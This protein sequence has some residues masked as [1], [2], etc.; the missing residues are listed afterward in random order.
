MQY[1]N[2]YF[3]EI[4]WRLSYIILAFILSISISY[5]HK[6]ELFYLVS[7]PFLFL[8]N[9]FIFFE[10]TEGL[11]SMIR[12]SS[13][14]SL[15]SMIPYII[16][17]FWSFYIPSCYEFERKRINF[18]LYVF[19]FFFLFEFFIIYWFLFP[20]LCEFLLSFEMKSVHQSF[21]SLSLEFA[22]R[23]TPYLTLIVKV[24]AFLLL[25]FQFPL[26]FIGL[27]RKH[28]VSSYNLC[29][30][31]K[32]S[33]FCCVLVSALISPPDFMSQLILSCIF[34]LIFELIIF[35]GFLFEIEDFEK[36]YNMIK[37]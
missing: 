34:Y 11:Y 35:I 9:Q 21:S 19:S 7:K 28:I 17:Q 12:I 8:S 6:Y 13:I 25:V 5:F 16:Y 2:Y 33:F 20:K 22:P 10:V 31:R 26:L 14:V 29:F 3:F 37:D 27:F 4:R 30:Q 18:L 1:I 15:V 36:E 24:F 32:L 23:I